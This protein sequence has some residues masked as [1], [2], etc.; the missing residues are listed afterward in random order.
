MIYV[1]ETANGST[2]AQLK[3][4]ADGGLIEHGGL[5]NLTRRVKIF[6]KMESRVQQANPPRKKMRF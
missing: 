1:E 3:K 6:K 4:D 2:A 5:L